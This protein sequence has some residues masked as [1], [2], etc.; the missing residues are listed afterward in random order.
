MIKEAIAKLV[1]RKNLSIEEAKSVMKEIMSGETTPALISAYLVSL[2]M[3]GETV[4]EITG[5]AEVMRENATLIQTKHSLIVDTCGTGGDKSDTFNVS[6]VSAFVVAGAG[7]PIAKHGNRAVSSKC[8]SADL[9][10]ALGVKLEI[11]VEKIEKCLNEIGLSYLFA[12]LLHSSMKYAT[13][14]R[15]EIGIR[16]IFNILGPLAN[17]AKVK[18]QVIGVYAP[19]LVEL[20]I[21]VLKNLGHSHAFVVH[22]ADGLDEISITGDTKVA[23]LKEGKILVYYIQPED[24]GIKSRKLDEIK[25]GTKEDNVKIALD[26]LNGEKGACR[27]MVVLNSSAGI[28]AGGK[29]NTL[30]E[31][32]KL[33]EESIDSKSALKKLELLREY[34][35]S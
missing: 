23:E 22:G 25:G 28:V 30:W 16:T 18:A 2:R 35:H 14:I 19:H 10:E 9:V 3:K 5:S 4:E 13:P 12:P 27:D 26:V 31:G 29:A 32:I 17:P 8:G 24:F 7:I 15:R 21:N 11:P 34:T 20:I 33:A 1:E 6:T